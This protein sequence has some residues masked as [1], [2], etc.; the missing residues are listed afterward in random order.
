MVEDWRRNAELHGD[1]NYAFLRSLKF[2]DYGFDPDELAAELHERAFGT[3]DCTRCAN[4]CKTLEI[5][6]TDDDVQRGILD[7]RTDAKPQP[8]LTGNQ[9]CRTGMTNGNSAKDRGSSSGICGCCR[10]SRPIGLLPFLFPF[11]VALRL[12]NPRR[13]PA[14]S[15]SLLATDEPLPE[16]PSSSSRILAACRRDR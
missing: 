12:R 13:L 6:I 4:C 11:P 8:W 7:R 3:V 14:R 1:A 9:P 5:K 2:R 15:L 16:F 10:V